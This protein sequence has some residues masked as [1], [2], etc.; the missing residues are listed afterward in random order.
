LL[1]W[2]L[3]LMLAPALLA[4]CK[5][6]PDPDVEKAFSHRLDEYVKLRKQVKSKNPAP[7]ETKDAS[8]IDSRKN[9]LA[10]GIRE[11][12]QG[13]RQGEVFGP[14]ISACLA[15]LMQN[16]LTASAKRAT[17]EGNP[18]VEGGGVNVEVNAAYPS[19][20]PLSSVPPTL[21][22]QLPKLP[23]EL[24]YRFV[25]RTLVLYDAEASLIVDFIPHVT[26]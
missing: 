14:E 8:Q 24:E 16:H 4:E 13:A 18:A 15:E 25:G 17:E 26:S 20:A 6:K 1:I 7:K 23:K 9:A 12:R 11:A 19:E 5:S 2:P 10:G 22:Q 21:L 3:A